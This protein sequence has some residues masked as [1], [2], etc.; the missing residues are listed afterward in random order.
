MKKSE[1]EELLPSNLPKKYF[2]RVTAAGRQCI[3]VN[4]DN[5]VLLT[6]NCMDIA[7]RRKMNFLYFFPTSVTVIAITSIYLGDGS[8]PTK[9]AIAKAMKHLEDSKKRKDLSSKRINR[10]KHELTGD[11]FNL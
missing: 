9:K 2:W 11:Y 8:E 6:D 7:L 3:V 5:E 10:M 1:L 4:K